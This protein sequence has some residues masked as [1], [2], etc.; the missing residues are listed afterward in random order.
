MTDLRKR[1]TEDLQLKG[2]SPATQQAYLMAVQK[3]AR[4]YGKSPSE[5]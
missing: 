3:L 1:M 4:H 5:M 2:L